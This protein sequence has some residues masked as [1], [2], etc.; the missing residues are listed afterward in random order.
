LPPYLVLVAVPGWGQWRL[1]RP[2]QGAPSTRSVS[3]DTPSV[4][5]GSDDEQATAT[6]VIGVGWPGSS[7]DWRLV[8]HLQQEFCGAESQADTHFASAVLE[9][10]RDQFC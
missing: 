10:V 2:S 6:F 9:G 1:L 3:A 8:A 4:W 5:K 7:S